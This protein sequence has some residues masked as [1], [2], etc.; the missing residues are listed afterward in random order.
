MYTFFKKKKESRKFRRV[1]SPAFWLPY[2]SHHHRTNN[3]HC[4]LVKPRNI[5]ITTEI[6][7]WQFFE[8]KKTR[9]C[10]STNTLT[11]K[12]DV[13]SQEP[14][15]FCVHETKAK[16]K[17]TNVISWFLHSTI[18]LSLLRSLLFFFLALMEFVLYWYTVAV[19][20]AVLFVCDTYLHLHTHTQLHMHTIPFTDS[21][22]IKVHDWDAIFTDC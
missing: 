8:K 2:Q 3:C 15:K 19:V 21:K 9:I 13:Y 4:H 10:S 5:S 22:S 11:H 6:T 1:K 7:A 12:T 14:I 16:E 18:Q 20:P 17:K